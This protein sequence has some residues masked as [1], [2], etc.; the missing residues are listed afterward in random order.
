MDARRMHTGNAGD[1]I[2]SEPSKVW[3]SS[4]RQLGVG[5]GKSS[6]VSCDPSQYGEKT[7]DVDDSL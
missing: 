3:G 5:E 1:K 2:A 6:T 7:L 4:V